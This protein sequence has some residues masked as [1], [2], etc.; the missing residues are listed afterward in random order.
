MATPA[1]P[2]P[3]RPQMGGPQPRHAPHPVRCECASLTAGK[4]GQGSLLAPFEEAPA[5]GEVVIDGEEEEEVEPLKNAANP[6]QPTAAQLE[7]H[8]ADHFP[9]RTWCKFC[10]M[11]RGVGQPHLAS[12]SEPTIAVVGLDYF[13]ITT[14]GVLRRNEL[15]I[16]ADD[17]AA[18]EDARGKGTVIKCLIVRCMQSKCIFA[19]VVPQKGD[20]EDHYCAGLAAADICWLGHTRVVLKCDN[21]SAVKALRARTARILKVQEHVTNVQEENPVVYDSQANGGVE[22]GVKIVRG[23]FR[24][25]KLCLEARLGKYLPVAHAITAWLLQ[26]ACTVINA[27]CRGPDGQTAWQRIKGRSFRQL[28]LGFGECVLYKLPSKGPQSA[29]DGNMGSRW[30]EGVFLGYNRSSNS[31]VI[32]TEAGTVSA[33][34]LYRRPIA[35]RWSLERISAIVATPWSLREKP[36][37]EARLAEN[38]EEQGTPAEPRSREI[39]DLPKAFRIAYKDLVEHGFTTDCPQCEHNELYQKSRGG[40]MHTDGCRKRLMDALMSTPA[41]RRRLET[42]ESRIDQAIADRGPEHA[43]TAGSGPRV[44][45]SDLQPRR[46]ATGHAASSSGLAQPTHVGVRGA[47]VVPSDELPSETPGAES[48]A[49]G[50]ENDMEAEAQEEMN[51]ETEDT[52]MGY[53]TALDDKTSVMLLEQLGHVGDMSEPAKQTRG[54]GVGSKPPRHD[55]FSVSEVYSPPRITL[56]L[57]KQRRSPLSPGLALDL[58]V[59]DPDDGKPW[60]FS[61]LAKRI[62]ARRLLQQARP[63]LLIGSPMCTAFSAWQQLNYAKSQDQ[64]K[65]RREYLKACVHLEFVAELYRDQLADGRYFLHEHPRSASSWDLSCMQ[66]LQ[67]TAG[68]E[69]VCGD[70][71]QYGAEAPHGPRKGDPVKKPTKFMSN[72]PEILHAL[73]RRCSGSRRSGPDAGSPEV[74]ESASEALP[75]SWCSRAKGGQHVACAGSICREMAKYPRELC[76]AVLRGLT[77]QLRA[78]GRLIPGCYGVQMAGARGTVEVEDTPMRRQHGPAEGYSGRFKDEMTGQVLKD[79]L[80]LQARDV[81]VTF[82]DK[83]GVWIKVPRRRAFERTGKP[84][85]STRWLDVNKGDE[86]HPNHRSRFVARQMK[87]LD[88]S[89]E[90]YFAP[91]PPLE[92]LRT[93]ISLTMTRCGPHQPVWDPKSSRRVQLSFIDISRAYFNAKVDREAAP[94]FVELPPEDPDRATMC[95]ELLRHMYG[96]RSAADGWQEEYSTTLVRMGFVQGFGHP[97]VFH[98]RERGIACS[99]HGDDFTSAGPADSLDWLESSI[100]AEYEI[101]LGPRLGPGPGD[102]KEARAL[103]RVIT[104]H[105]D[106]VEYEADPRQ[107]ERLLDELGLS[108]DVTAVATPGVKFSYQDHVTDVPLEGKLHTPFRGSAARG[109]YL[110]ADRVDVQYAAKE[111][112]RSMSAPT[113]LSWKALKRLGRFLSGKPRLVYVFRKQTVDSID[114]Y[115]DTEWAGCA[116][117]R[118]STSGGVVMLGRHTIKHWSST[119]PSVTLSSGEAEFYGVVRGSGQGL[120]YQALLKDLGVAAPLRVWTDSS[121]ALG[122]CSRQGLGK[123]RHL[124]THTLWVQQAVRSGRL[125]RKKVPG[126]RNP[127]DLLTK[128]SIS[129]EKAEQLVRLYDCYYRDGRAESAP[130][131]RTG[132]SEKLTLAK[133]GQGS[134][135]GA[136]GATQPCMPHTLW[137]QEELD[138]RYPS[139]KAVTDL[140]LDD[141][142][143]LEDECLY[144]AGMSVVQ[145]ILEEMTTQGRRRRAQED[146]GLGDGGVPR[147]D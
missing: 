102:A 8:R 17:K 106:R 44:L 22:V 45:S 84:P 127:A 109:N 53:I 100:A 21:E 18:L 76:Q 37:R 103:N 75:G 58:T 68:V 99:V 40:F 125:Q 69:T 36:D 94:C 137:A 13:F 1:S 93:V 146:G 114:I 131:M 113:S 139:L 144:T 92:A 73:S 6:A 86:E 136:V 88:R 79:K 50:A 9:F 10:I 27:R 112:C 107:A 141:L 61:L 87:R 72:S 145:G 7:E 38:A 35:N 116:R 64:E 65:M 16:A 81:E 24:T 67:S 118:K 33:R 56:E 57:R 120:G 34:S 26:H 104:W 5:E 105:E 123:F 85:I 31:Y 133:A 142:S 147:P 19:H 70:Q 98:H 91:A 63:I 130:A 62:K 135:L 32:A 78:D 77:A 90:T 128:H 117:T 15:A 46:E 115:V 43:W 29:P 51:D 60:D 55:G 134:E 42:Y 25:L 126:E 11:G 48:E 2:K 28:L 122:I 74:D 132:A 129:Q 20:D 80:V 124:D 121:A 66:R 119:Q 59:N 96:T 3:L 41:G 30:L 111:I 71:C 110:S 108:G 82:F 89:G 97:N 54:K 4:S 14:E 83:K 52:E 140:E 143:R 47:L 95:G 12:Q 23:V 49:H 101:T 39:A 138:I